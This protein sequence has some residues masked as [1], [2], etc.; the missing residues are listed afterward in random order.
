MYASS[1]QFGS[2]QTG[3]AAVK[4]CWQNLALG[5]APINIPSRYHA[6]L[7]QQ[8]LTYRYRKTV[9]SLTCDNAWKYSILTLSRRDQSLYFLATMLQGSISRDRL[10]WTQYSVTQQ[11]EDKKLLTPQNVVWQIPWDIC[12]I[13]HSKDAKTDHPCC[14]FLDGDTLD[15]PNSLE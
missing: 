6:L 9:C 7:P 13:P 5:Q 10:T 3:N 14:Q 4:Y 1:S 11:Q 2:T 8:I 12:V 15:S